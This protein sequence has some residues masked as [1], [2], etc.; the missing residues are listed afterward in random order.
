M[1]RLRLEQRKGEREDIFAL[2]AFLTCLPKMTPD[3][4]Q[5]F[6]NYVW[7]KSGSELKARCIRCVP[8]FALLT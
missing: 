8:A 1:K 4:I 7:S 5:A 6:A 2:R 3:E